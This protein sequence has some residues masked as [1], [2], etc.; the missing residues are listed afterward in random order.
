MTKA[1]LVSR[2]H[3][4]LEGKVTKIH[5]EKVVDAIF[6]SICDEFIAGR[7]VTVAHLGT[8][9]VKT[10]AAREARNPRTGETVHVGEKKT[11]T[12]KPVPK[13]KNDINASSKKKQDSE[14]PSVKQ[15][16]KKSVKK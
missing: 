12:F 7:D 3:E 8:F 16:T 15:V 1:D 13:L 6:D 4:V 9:K 2:V 14:K 11:I 10:R 5:A